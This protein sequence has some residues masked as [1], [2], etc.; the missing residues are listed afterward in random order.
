MALSYEEFLRSTCSLVEVKQ[1]LKRR[2]DYDADVV[3]A[4]EAEQVVIKDEVVAVD[5]DSNCATTGD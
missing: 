2:A 4:Y 3:T 5:E 1:I